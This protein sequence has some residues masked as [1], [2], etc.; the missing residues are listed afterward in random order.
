MKTCKT[1][2]KTCKTSKN[3]G[4]ADF[5]YVLQGIYTTFFCNF[6]RYCWNENK[7]ILFYSLRI[8][9][10]EGKVFEEILFLAKP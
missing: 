6:A 1:Y 5:M 2:R 9:I 8:E 7:E 4:V 3:E 10:C